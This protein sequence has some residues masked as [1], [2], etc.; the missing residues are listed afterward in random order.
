MNIG[1]GIKKV[2]E[3]HGLSQQTL[4]RRVCVSDNYVSLMES[5]RKTPSWAM[6][7]RLAAALRVSVTTLVDEAEKL[8]G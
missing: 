8:P 5:N 4:T 2:R 1:G 6:I 7:C 3:D